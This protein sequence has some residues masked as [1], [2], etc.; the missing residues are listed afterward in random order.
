MISIINIRLDKTLV[1]IDI[2][3]TNTSKQYDGKEIIQ[4][5]LSKPQGILDKEKLSL[6]AF[7]KTRLLKPNETDSFTATFDLCDAASYS[8]ESASFILEKGE[9]GIFAGTNSADTK[10]ITV[11]S[12]DETVITRKL[13][14][15]CPVKDKF[16]QVVIKSDDYIFS[17]DIQGYALEVQ[18]L[19]PSLLFMNTGYRI[20]NDKVKECLD[21]FTA[22]ELIEV[23][24][25]G[26][27]SQKV[28]NIIS[29]VAGK[30]SVKLL[31]K[32]I[33]NINMA[34][35]PSG[36]YIMPKNAYTKT[37]SPRYVDELPPDW[38]WGWLKKFQK[39]VL[40]KPGKGLRAF[41]YM[42]AFPAPMLQAQ[43]WNLDLIE[44]IGKA[45][46]MKCWSPSIHMAC[47]GMN[48]HKILMREKLRILFRRSVYIRSNGSCCNKRSPES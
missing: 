30:T 14:N 7:K 43:S 33:P 46:E 11:I 5:Y 16:E 34:D 4:I 45:I 19:I 28:Y 44:D 40:A 47:S 31:N 13:T 27:Y 32:G 36:L 42:T 1:S 26:G 38:Q 6:V 23:C 2:S 41:H 24:I 22:N 3:V 21:T 48:I 20:K 18:S 8:E 12:L 10:P 39:Y 37:G 9:Y 25:G 29:G 17:E 15:I 35:G